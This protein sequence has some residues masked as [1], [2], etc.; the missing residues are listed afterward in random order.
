M[1]CHNWVPTY[2]RMNVRF[3]YYMNLV[4]NLLRLYYVE[5]LQKL[6]I[7]SWEMGKNKRNKKNMMNLCA[8]FHGNDI[9]FSRN[10]IYTLY[11][12]WWDIFEYTSKSFIPFLCIHM[13][14]FHSKYTSCLSFLWLFVNAHVWS[15]VGSD[16]LLYVNS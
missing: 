14:L 15:C 6:V 1:V 11:T 9:R 13:I 8:S 4:W 5:G 16:M 10:S 12:I 7:H 2:T 3:R